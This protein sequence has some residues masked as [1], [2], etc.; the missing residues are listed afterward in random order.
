MGMPDT[1]PRKIA[2]K[3]A[4]SKASI[5][6]KIRKVQKGFGTLNKMWTSQIIQKED[7]NV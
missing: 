3:S 7:Q 1:K 6:Q 5:Q 4:R 2:Q